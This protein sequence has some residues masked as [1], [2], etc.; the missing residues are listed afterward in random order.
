MKIGMQLLC[1]SKPTYRTRATNDVYV[2]DVYKCTDI[3]PYAIDD[4]ERD[5]NKRRIALGN[6]KWTRREHFI[7][8]PDEIDRR[9][10]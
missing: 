1:I 6:G 5:I 4:D 2:G 3:C 10:K 9:G 7:S 8:L